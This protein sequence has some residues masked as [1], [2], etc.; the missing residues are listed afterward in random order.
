MSKICTIVIEDEINCRIGGLHPA[1]LNALWELFGIYVDGYRFMPAFQLRRWDGK[2]R[3]LDKHGKTYTK[4]LEEIIPHIIN[5]NYEIR[6]EDRRIEHIPTQDIITEDFFE[7]QVIKLRPYQIEAATKLLQIGSG[8]GVLAT[9]AGKT[10]LCAVMAQCLRNIQHNT[11]IIVPSQDLV[12]Q[13]VNELREVLTG[14]FPDTLIGAYSGDVK[15]IDSH[16]VVA[17]WQ[18]L[19]HVP[20]Y[21]GYFQAVIV[22]ECFAPGT[23]VLTPSGYKLIESMRC[24]DNIISYDEIAKQFI[25]DEVVKLHENLTH[26]ASE[27]MYE[28]TFD[29]D[30]VLKVTGNHKF[31]T[32]RGWVRADELTEDD[33]IVNAYSHAVNAERNDK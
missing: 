19:Q 17:T 25:I 1:D 11:I 23:K 18:A 20:H 33:E 7:H 9:S 2:T 27:D 24:G 5:W 30:V 29:N 14:K 3:W 8:F 26:T 12:D 16:I 22:D 6:F 32:G 28:L 10:L 15:Q 13:T 31:L 21:M 4:L